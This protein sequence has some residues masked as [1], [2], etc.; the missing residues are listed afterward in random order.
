MK[1]FTSF[2]I[3]LLLAVF[4]MAQGETKSFTV[5]P[6]DGSFKRNGSVTT[7]QWASTWTSSSDEYPVVTL[8]TTQNN[9]WPTTVDS[10][11]FKLAAGSNGC[12]YTLSV[13]NCQIQS[14]SSSVIEAFV[15]ASLRMVQ[16]ASEKIA[17]NFSS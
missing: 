11:G 6:T 2:L 4:A 13:A 3:S 7:T 9:I 10:D 17:S 14:Y 16:A 8:S 12:T 5:N 15:Y 1:R